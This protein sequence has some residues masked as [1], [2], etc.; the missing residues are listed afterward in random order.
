MN[1]TTNKRPTWVTIIAI[2]CILFGCYGIIAGAQ[3]TVLPKMLDM[4]KE[5]M[6]SL[7]SEGG[8]LPEQQKKILN[9]LT[10][11][12][13]YPDW[14]PAWSVVS[15]VLK[16]L[17]SIAYLIAGILLLQLKHYAVRVFYWA[18]GCS[19]AVALFKAIIY[20]A[21][22]SFAGIIMAGIFGWIIDIVLIVIVATSNKSA[23]YSEHV[24]K[25]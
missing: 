13:N 20:V 9:Q 18:A 24:L 4:Q 25:A 6:S 2:L 22:M 8:N 12:W 14:F 5:A 7:F 17:V 21:A 23:F 16:I 19:I 15:G 10:E 11:M 3:E 1:T